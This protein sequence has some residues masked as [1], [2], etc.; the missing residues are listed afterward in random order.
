LSQ[1]S[2]LIYYFVANCFLWGF[3]LNFNGYLIPLNFTIISCIFLLKLFFD[4]GI[5]KKALEFTALLFLFLF[6]HSVISL[7]GVCENLFDKSIV[8]VFAFSFAFLVGADIGVKSSDK[9]WHKFIQASKYIFSIAVLGLLTEL[10]FKDYFMSTL[11]YRDKGVLTGLFHAEPS[12][13][14]FSIYPIIAFCLVGLV[15]RSK[16]YFCCMLILCIIL[17][18]SSTMIALTLL[19]AIFLFSSGNIKFQSFPLKSLFLPILLFMII[20]SHNITAPLYDRFKSFLNPLESTNLSGLVLNQGLSDSYLNLIRTYG[21]G[22][23]FNR[24]GCE[25][26]INSSVR[27]AIYKLNGSGLNDSDGSFLVSKLISEL[28]LF[29]FLFVLYLVNFAY[30]C[31][32][33]PSPNIINFAKYSSVFIIICS[34]FIRSGGYYSCS[35]LILIPILFSLNSKRI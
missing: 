14:A 27:D 30:I 35:L 20:F 21:Y 23:G 19:M 18:P 24:M 1:S 5:S 32:R 31:W 6:I 13:F 25:P 16:L 15:H 7:F 8:N 22:L 10:T 17:S 12:H 11:D 33:R 28:G 9:D 29:A 4:K 3:D 2:Y 34:F 26:V